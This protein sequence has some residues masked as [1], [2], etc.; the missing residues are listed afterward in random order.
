MTSLENIV[1]I[2]ARKGSQ[3]VRNKN[4]RIIAGKPLIWHTINYAL[5]YIKNSKIIVSTDCNE[6]KKIAKRFYLDIYD[7][8]VKLAS[9]KSSMYDVLEDINKQLQ[10]N[11]FKTKFITLLQPTSPIRKKNLINR[12]LSIMK[13][14]KEFSS[15]IHVGQ[16][17][18]FTGS[19]KRNC[20][21][22]DFLETTRSQDIPPKYVP[23]GCLFIYNVL[24]TIDKG[25]LL[26][27][28][29][30]AYV[31]KTNNWV[32][33]DYEHDLVY[34]KFLHQSLKRNKHYG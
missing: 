21:I 11:G 14:N 25:S 22:P 6:V 15:L 9:S 28:K 17:K 4:I 19:V 7:R 12:G 1:V 24:K 23:T 5:K 29:T 33:I 2:P 20:W 27:D 10:K 3:R 8:P 32:N 13:K 31:E 26:G 30:Y 16:I 18:E 34:F